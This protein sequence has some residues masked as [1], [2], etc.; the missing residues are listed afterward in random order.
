[1]T[2]YLSAV[3]VLLAMESQPQAWVTK[4]TM[5]AGLPENVQMKTGWG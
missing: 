5:D 2:S 3:D 1:M 4:I